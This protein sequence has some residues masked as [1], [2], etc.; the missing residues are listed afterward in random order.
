MWT[1][2]CVAGC[3]NMPASIAGAMRMAEHIASAV[4]V[5]RLSAKPWA[6]LASVLAVQGAMTSKSAL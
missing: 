2:S 4:M 5:S 1:F 3:S 6:S